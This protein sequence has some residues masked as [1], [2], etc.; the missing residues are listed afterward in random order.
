M[1]VA[2]DSSQQQFVFT[3]DRILYP[4]KIAYKS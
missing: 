2:G 4:Y 3:H 1:V